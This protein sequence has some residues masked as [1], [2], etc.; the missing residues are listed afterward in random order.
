MKY[1]QY[2]QEDLWFY[3]LNL[4]GFAVV[5][6]ATWL[7]TRLRAT[8][9]EQQYQTQ[10][11]ALRLQHSTALQQPQR[12]L[13]AQREHLRRLVY[14]MTQALRDQN[15][16]HL[17]QYRHQLSHC[18]IL[19]YLPAARR[20]WQL[21][22]PLEGAAP[23][24]PWIE[25]QVVTVLETSRQVLAALNAKPVLAALPTATEVVLQPQELAAAFRLLREA[26]QQPRA[27]AFAQ[28]LDLRWEPQRYAA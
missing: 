18:L 9:I 19:D 3:A 28:A 26:Q 7:W 1:L 24:A 17:R 8:R 14:G 10:L 12:Y 23:S 6:L 11:Q 13:D 21:Q 22:R 27:K 5:V 15:L 20:L 2:L 16:P 4:L 25:E